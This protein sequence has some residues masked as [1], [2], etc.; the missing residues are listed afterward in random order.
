M[1]FPSGTQ[2][3]SLS[4]ARVML[5][6]LCN[7]RREASHQ[8][9]WTA[10]NWCFPGTYWPVALN[11]ISLRL[12][13]WTRGGVLECSVVLGRVWRGLCSVS[14]TNFIPTTYS[15][16]FSHA[17]TPASASFFMTPQRFPASLSDRLRIPSSCTWK[18]T[19][20]MP[21]KEAAAAMIVGRLGS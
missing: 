18:R 8:Q 6:T 14:R 19:A 7:G 2:N 13:R 4:H 10:V 12:N 16:N 21:F 1:G 3:F 17:Q 15:L 9:Y 11:L 20:P 5:N